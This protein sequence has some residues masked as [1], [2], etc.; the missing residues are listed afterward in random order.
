MAG[1]ASVNFSPFD[2][3]L[4]PT[5]TGIRFKKYTERFKNYLVAIDIKDKVRKRAIFLHLQK[6]IKCIKV[7][8]LPN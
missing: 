6:L 7:Q 3:D 2:P 1:E 8:R 5:T 4:E